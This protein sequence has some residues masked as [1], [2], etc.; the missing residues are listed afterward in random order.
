MVNFQELGVNQMTKMG[1]NSN[2]L[3]NPNH[4]KRGLELAEAGK[5]QEALP[6][7]QEHLRTTGGNA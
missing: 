2:Q 4:Y 6:C 3:G 5:Y 7:M 1:I